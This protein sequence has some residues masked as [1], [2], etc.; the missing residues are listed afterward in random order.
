[1]K[2][3]HQLFLKWRWELLLFA[4]TAVET[5]RLVGFSLQESRVPAD[6]LGPIELPQSKTQVGRNDPQQCQ[7]LGTT[8][9]VL[10]LIIQCLINRIMTVGY[11][12]RI[13]YQG[14]GVRCQL[15]PLCLERRQNATRRTFPPSC[16]INHLFVQLCWRHDAM[17]AAMDFL[18]SGQRKGIGW[19]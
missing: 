15:S 11:L 14:T 9:I 3:V 12:E 8:S 16:V 6:R 13:G 10:K 18:R 5:R 2:L 4:T 7:G 1:M 19:M 17:R